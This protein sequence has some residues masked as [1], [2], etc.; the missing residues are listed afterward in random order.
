MKDAE[1]ELIR[2]GKV[3]P[4]PPDPE[5]SVLEEMERGVQAHRAQALWE[6]LVKEKRYKEAEKVGWIMWFQWGIDS[7]LRENN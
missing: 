6:R 3:E 1:L 4:F 5:I 7:N 2:Q